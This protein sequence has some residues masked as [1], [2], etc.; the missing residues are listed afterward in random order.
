[1][2][3]LIFVTVILSFLSSPSFGEW[4]EVGQNSDGVRF[5]EIDTVRK[6]ESLSYYNFLMDYFEP[7]I[8]GDLST[9]GREVINCK[10]KKFKILTQY[11]FKESMGR[12][13]GEHYHFPMDW[14]D[15]RMDSIIGKSY[16]SVC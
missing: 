4:K 13:K 14:T 11:Y 7:S 3:N 5:I 10:T 8:G 2:K 6:K 16:K 1:L 9:K 15:F 12:G